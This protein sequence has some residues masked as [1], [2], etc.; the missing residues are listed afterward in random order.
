VAREVAVRHDR[1]SQYRSVHFQR[2]LRWLGITDDPAYVGE[3]ETNGCA[4]P[5]IKT[6]KEHCLW[7]RPYDDVDD[8]RQAVAGFVDLDNTQ[9]LIERHGHR[10][11]QEAYLA[12]L[13]SEAA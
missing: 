5:W 13:N 7:A 10:T 1:G 3:P 2:S 9:W 4:E 12:S 8:R 11:P 6:L